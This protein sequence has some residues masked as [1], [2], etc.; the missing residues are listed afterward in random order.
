MSIGSHS[1]IMLASGYPGKKMFHFHLCL[2]L[3]LSGPTSLPSHLRYLNGKHKRCPSN[4]SLLRYTALS[5]PLSSGPPRLSQRVTWVCVSECVTVR[6]LCIWA[7]VTARI[8]AHCTSEHPVFKC[9]LSGRRTVTVLSQIRCPCDTMCLTPVYNKVSH[10]T[11]KDMNSGILARAEWLCF[12]KSFVD[13]IWF[14]DQLT[15]QQIK[16][17]IT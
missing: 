9:Q 10:C 6:V 4:V 16:L 5:L 14:I 15:A 2:G 1:E 12:R 7:S 3:P 17:L 11:S 13:L 8:T